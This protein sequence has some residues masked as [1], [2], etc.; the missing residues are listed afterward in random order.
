MVQWI[1]ALAAKTEVRVQCPEPT[2]WGRINQRFSS[3]RLW[4]VHG[5][6]SVKKCLVCIYEHTYVS[7]LGFHAVMKHH[8]QKQL[9]EKR[10]Y[11]DL[12]FP[13]NTPSL[14]EA[15]A[16][17]DTEGIEKYYLLASS[18][19]PCSTCFLIESCTTN[20][21]FSPPTVNYQ[22]RT[23]PTGLPPVFWDICSVESPSS[24]VTLACAKLT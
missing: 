24:Q 16:G 9:G 1:K 17:T 3:D 2:W 4:H 10:V 8:D 14:R 13:C 22:L 20:P 18:I 21:G 19:M 7:Q 5:Y 23:F 15:R 11:F 6:I 12:E